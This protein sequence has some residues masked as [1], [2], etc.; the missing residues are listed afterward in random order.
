[1]DDARPALRVPDLRGAVTE[2]AN[3][4]RET[5][6][7]VGLIFSTPPLALVRWRGGASTFEPLDGIVQATQIVS[8]RRA[9]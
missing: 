1:M 8:E 3:P 4:G 7:L 9:D 5:G 6:M 2:R